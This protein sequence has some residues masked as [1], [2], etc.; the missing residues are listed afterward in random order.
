MGEVLREFW[1][2]KVR[3]NLT[4]PCFFYLFFLIKSARR[5]PASAT[6]EIRRSLDFC[7]YID[8]QEARI[9]AQSNIR[10]R[11][12][13][14][15]QSL[16]PALTRVVRQCGQSGYDSA[17]S[18]ALP[19]F[20]IVAGRT[21]IRQA[22][23]RNCPNRLRSFALQPAPPG[24]GEAR[25]RRHS[26]GRRHRHRVSRSPDPGNRQAPDSVSRPQSRLS[27]PRGSALRLSARW[28][29]AHRRLRQDHAG[30]THGGSHG[31]HPGHRAFGGP[32]AQW[33]VPG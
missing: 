21:A 1:T 32:D 14:Q 6:L 10:R 12:E 27:Q 26:R 2:K 25:A 7:V 31:Q 18:G 33:L 17:L 30:A 22:H 19:E 16:F 5:N 28:R 13:Q 11:H 20:R 23:H 3:E 8:W 9:G 4:K 15:S 29:R 24:T